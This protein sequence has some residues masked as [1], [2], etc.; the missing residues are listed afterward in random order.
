M[1]I[2]ENWINFSF[3]CFFIEY[4]KDSDEVKNQEQLK[5]YLGLVEIVSHSVTQSA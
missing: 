2:W 3:F 4:F 1:N 5:G